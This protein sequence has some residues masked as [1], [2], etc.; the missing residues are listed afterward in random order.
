MQFS[1][2]AKKLEDKIGLGDATQIIKDFGG[3]DVFTTLNS[4]ILR[5]AFMRNRYF[6]KDIA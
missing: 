3:G 6:K 5:S 2:A 4:A 1:Y